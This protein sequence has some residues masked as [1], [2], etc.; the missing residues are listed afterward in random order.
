[1]YGGSVASTLGAEQRSTSFHSLNPGEDEKGTK[2]GKSQELGLEVTWGK[3]AAGWKVLF[4]KHTSRAISN[5]PKEMCL[6]VPNVMLG[7]ESSNWRAWGKVIRSTLEY[8]I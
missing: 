7:R 4:V 1:M 8:D 5:F 2:P 3:E 6:S